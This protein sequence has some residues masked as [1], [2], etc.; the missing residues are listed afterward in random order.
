MQLNL[1]EKVL[2]VLGIVGLAKSLFGLV[3]PFALKKAAA[4]WAGA[5]KHVNSLAGGVCILA[6]AA[7][8]VLVLAGQAL[9]VWILVLIGFGFAW[10]GTL[11]FRVESFQKLLS[12]LY[13][14]RKRVA[15]RLIFGFGAVISILLIWVALRR[16]LLG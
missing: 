3:K 10:L 15:L 6:G 14:D 7:L 12:V 2:L 11:Y 4:W 13:L 5:M 16:A 8:W 9:T 1:H